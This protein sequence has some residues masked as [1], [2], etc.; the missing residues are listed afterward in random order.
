MPI[1][2]M[3]RNMGFVIIAAAEEALRVKQ[4]AG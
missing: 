4:Q 2:Y 3:I 1:M